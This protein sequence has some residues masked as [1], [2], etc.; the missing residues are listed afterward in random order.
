MDTIKPKEERG[1]VPVYIISP[2]DAEGEPID[3]HF[4]VTEGGLLIHM[5]KMDEDIPES[6][7]TDE[8]GKLLFGL[9]HEQGRYNEFV[10]NPD[11]YKIRMKVVSPFSIAEARQLNEFYYMSTEDRKRKLREDTSWQR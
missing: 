5:Q 11:H 8:M 2:K 1:G 9:E 6:V 10:K 7:V 3:L 4:A